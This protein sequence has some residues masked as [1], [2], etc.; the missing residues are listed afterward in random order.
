MR[1]F[2]SAIGGIV[3][4]APGVAPT[5]YTL[6][7]DGNVPGGGNEAGAEPENLLEFRPEELRP[8]N[9]FSSMTPLQQR[10]RIAS[11]ALSGDGEFTSPDMRDYYKDVA[12][13][14]LLDPMGTPAPFE[15]V[16]PIE[17]QYVTTVLGQGDPRDTEGFLRSLLR[18]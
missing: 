6:D 3:S 10:T 15:S 11:G 2:L 5:N 13:F 18:G 17:R 9:G 7:M 12:F 4:S 16:T 8:R 14:S 1:D